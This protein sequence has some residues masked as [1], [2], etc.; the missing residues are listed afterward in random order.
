MKKN[1][2]WSMSVIM[3]V[4]ILSVGVASCGDDEIEPQKEDPQHPNES[5]VDYLPQSSLQFVGYWHGNGNNYDFLFLPTGVCFQYNNWNSKWIG[6]GHWS[7]NPET[8]LLSTTISNYSW[9]I[10]IVTE[11]DWSGVRFGGKGAQSYSRSE[12]L[13]YDFVNGYL[14]KTMWKTVSG[15]ILEFSDYL[16]DEI[17]I[18]SDLIKGAYWVGKQN[19]K[20][21]EV[22]GDL[23]VYRDGRLHGG[24]NNFDSLYIRKYLS[25][26]PLIEFEGVKYNAVVE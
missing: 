13:S 25:K 9:V 19:L 18:K 8:S 2:L 16:S 24:H 21:K 23:K 26:Q 5:D 4:A 22:N 20:A 12:Y 17:M 11:N 10:N 14:R 15:S 1:F 6:D 7:F 3:M